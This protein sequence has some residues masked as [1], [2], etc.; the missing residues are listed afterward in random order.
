MIDP[1]RLAVE[2]IGPVGQP[3]RFDACED[4]VELSFADEKCEMNRRDRLRR[5]Q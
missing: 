5:R 1:A 3:R 4:F 2:R